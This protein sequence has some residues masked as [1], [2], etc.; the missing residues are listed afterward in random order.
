MINLTTKERVEAVNCG[1]PVTAWTVTLRWPM[2]SPRSLTRHDRR[3]MSTGCSRLD[4]YT[5]LLQRTNHTQTHRQLTTW[6]AVKQLSSADD[7]HLTMLYKIYNCMVDTDFTSQL[8]L[9]QSSTRDHASRFLQPKCSC[10]AYSNS[11]LPRT[12]RD[13]NALATDPLLFQT[14]HAFKIYLFTDPSFHYFR[15]YLVYFIT[16]R[17]RGLPSRCAFIFS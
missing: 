13:W 6:Q 5:K 10:A 17:K 7:S 15:S 1:S 2:T 4:R 9:T 16:C 8:T 11:F 12:I 3:V 14:I